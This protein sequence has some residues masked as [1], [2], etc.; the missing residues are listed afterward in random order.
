MK[1]VIKKGQ[2]RAWPPHI[3]MWVGKKKIQYRV[4]FGYGCNYTIPGAD[5]EDTNKLFGL[6]YCPLWKGIL[7]ATGAVYLG[8]LSNEQHTDSARFG[9]VYKNG[10]MQ[11]RAYLYVNGE[12]IIEDLCQVNVGFTY[13]FFLFINHERNYYTFRV[14]NPANGWVLAERDFP[15]THDKKFSFPLDPFFGGNQRAPHEMEISMQK[16]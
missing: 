14:K 12:R 13:D 15:F 3:G 16:I 5:Q 9:W 2:H 6:G 8:L 11:I 10:K 7:C 4:V 1:Y